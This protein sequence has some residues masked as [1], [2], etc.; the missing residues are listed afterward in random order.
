MADRGVAARQWCNRLFDHGL[1]TNKISRYVNAVLAVLIMVNVGCVILESVESLRDSHGLFFWWVE[2]IATVIFAAEYGL[3]VWTAVDRA[4]GRFAH[5]VFG[6]LRYMVR[7][8][9]VIDLIAILPAMLGMFGAD[10][11]RVLR[12]LRL[13]RMLKLTR[14]S[15]A[16]SLLWAVFREEANTIL[17]ILFVLALSLLMSASLMYMVENEVQPAVFSSIPAAMWWAITTLTTVGYGDMVP[18]TALGRVLGGL[19]SVVGIGTFAL[20]SGVLTA[21]FMNQVRIRREKYRQLVEAGVATGMLTL[22]DLAMIEAMGE[23]LGIGKSDSEDIAEETLLDLPHGHGHC[24]NCGYH[25]G[26]PPLDE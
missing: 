13:L 19:V 16:F 3:R 5:P 18:M 11:L 20:F 2:Q 15:T 4:G 24:P 14:H 1:P 23:D 10:D 26:T 6:R 7:F 25:L 22:G 8:F 17:A 9:S 21:S 12:L